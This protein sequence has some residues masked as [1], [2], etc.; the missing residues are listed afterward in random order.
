MLKSIEEFTFAHLTYDGAVQIYLSIG[1]LPQLD[2]EMNQTHFANEFDH[3]TDD[4]GFGGSG[5]WPDH[6]DDVADNDL[7]YDGLDRD[8]DGALLFDENY[9]GGSYVVCD[10]DFHRSLLMQNVYLMKQETELQTHGHLM[11]SN[12]IL[13]MKLV[14]VM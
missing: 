11:M 7:P 10:A 4:F 1:W 12:L 8:D 5:G 13:T 14:D 9:V 3:L 6:F 2:F